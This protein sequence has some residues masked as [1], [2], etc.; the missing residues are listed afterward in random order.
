MVA[1]QRPHGVET[2]VSR[3]D[4]VKG[5][6]RG[7]GINVRLKV[8]GEGLH[9]DTR[10]DLLALRVTDVLLEYHR[11]TII[12]GTMPE[13]GLPKK[14]LAVVALYAGRNQQMPPAER[15]KLGKRKSMHRGYASGVLAA[16]LRRSKVGGGARSARRAT[17]RIVPPTNR[18][19]IVAQELTQRGIDYFGVDGRAAGVIRAEIDAA[20]Q[21][22]LGGNMGR[23]LDY[24]A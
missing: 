17:A 18:N 8:E 19:V 6:R 14:P 21:D 13:S 20:I 24:G 22:A 23:Y 7:D 16:G 15:K 12:N 1:Q 2:I 3:Q 11:E 9:I 4:E 5:T 10:A